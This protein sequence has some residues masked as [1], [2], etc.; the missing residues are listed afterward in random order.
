[1]LPASLCL[2]ATPSLVVSFLTAQLSP[3]C[4]LHPLAFL[5]QDLGQDLGSSCS[6]SSSVPLHR[7][8]PLSSRRPCIPFSNGL[9]P[10]LTSESVGSLR[11]QSPPAPQPHNC[12]QLRIAGSQGLLALLGSLLDKV[13]SGDE[14]LTWLQA[15]SGGGLVLPVPG[16]APSCTWMILPE[17]A[18]AEHG[19]WVSE[20]ETPVVHGVLLVTGARKQLPVTM[21]KL[22]YI[23]FKFLGPEYFRETTWVSSF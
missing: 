9:R 18:E 6:Y 17:T 11:A 5:S 7:T 14:N 2:P 21:V 13:A 19:S 1:M 23:F 22:L 16:L 12:R 4:W 8:A 10:S 3:A 20:V 15:G